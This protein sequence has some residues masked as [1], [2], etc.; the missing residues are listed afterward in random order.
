MIMSYINNVDF[1]KMRRE[2]LAHWARHT[3]QPVSK[4]A[5]DYLDKYIGYA[6]AERYSKFG[7]FNAND[8]MTKQM[9]NPQVGHQMFLHNIMES[10][11]DEVSY[12]YCGI[13]HS[14]KAFGTHMDEESTRRKTLTGDLSIDTTIP[15]KDQAFDNFMQPGKV[16][17]IVGVGIAVLLVMSVGAIGVSTYIKKKREK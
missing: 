14:K 3:G 9:N 2:I 7:I 13:E 6:K 15:W 8:N 10:Y 1:V 11:V 12:K 5:T 17:P 16:I 4:C